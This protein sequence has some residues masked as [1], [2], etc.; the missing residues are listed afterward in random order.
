VK[1]K[2]LKQLK[3]LP[4]NNVVYAMCEPG[5]EIIRY[6]G[7]AVN[8]YKR[9]QQH[10]APCNLIKHTHKNNW[11]KSLIAKEQDVKIIILAQANS[12]EELDYLEIKWIAECRALGLNLTNYLDG[13]NVSMRG[14]KISS[15]TK[16]KMSDALIGIYKRIFTRE[17]EFDICHLYETSNR[18]VIKNKYK[19]SNHTLKRILKDNN[20]TLHSL[21]KIKKISY[22]KLTEQQVLDIRAEYV[23]GKKGSGHKSLA[24]KYG[25]SG[26]NIRDILTRKTWKWI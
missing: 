3:T 1:N 19:I 12:L 16:K 17:E 20:I 22:Q 4:Q 26:M 8:L 24:K 11:I 7:Q 10:Y 13:G 21:R 23:R 9:M 14:K 5:T 2:F 15:E 6:V 18:D 25:V